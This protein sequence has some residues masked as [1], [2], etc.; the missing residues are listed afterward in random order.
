MRPGRKRQFKIK[1]GYIEAPGQAVCVK[2]I[3]G[4]LA[5]KAILKMVIFGL[6]IGLN[7]F[8]FSAIYQTLGYLNDKETA[9]G[10]FSAGA[11]DFILS[12]PSDFTP[13]AL[14]PGESATRIIELINTAN[15][16]QYNITAGS[17]VGNLCQ[18][19]EA[20]VSL[21]GG[22]ILYSGGLEDFIYG[23]VVFEAP[24]VWIFVLTLPV[25]APE[26]AQGET[27]QYN[28][29]F[30][31]SQTRNNLPFGLGFNDVEEIGSNIASKFCYDSETRSKGYWKNHESVYL[32]HLPQIL[33]CAAQ[34]PIQ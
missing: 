34:S 26:S 17:F 22:A 12:S 9:G 8:G 32:P 10:Y 23:P 27:C 24:D 16:P 33:K 4:G 29:V 20:E 14:A 3:K 11:L 31:G 6:I 18:Y 15:I 25:D 19:L 2:I 28:S 7:W 5:R 1:V 30:F 13:F 21:D